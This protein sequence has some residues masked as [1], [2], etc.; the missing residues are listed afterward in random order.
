MFQRIALVS[1][2]LASS[3][4]HATTYTFEPQHA[5]GIVRWNHLGYSH[6]TAQFTRLEGTLDFDPANPTQASVAVNIPIANLSSGV[7]DLD[8]YL[9]AE[10]F[11]DVAKFPTASFKSTKVEKGS[12][13]DQFK[14]SGNFSLHGVTKAVVL[15]AKL[16]KIGT[17][18]RNNLPCIGFEVMATLKRSDF[19]LGLYVPQVS[20]EVEIHITAQGDESKGW[21]EEMKKIAADAARSAKVAADKAAAAEAAS[22]AAMDTEKKQ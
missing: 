2:I 13:P 3:P 22:K 19:G 12:T 16:N 11:F 4:L 18:P 21:A 6:P 9:R 8:D 5:E 7:P 14:V 17:N 10:E 1:L 20:D 15:N